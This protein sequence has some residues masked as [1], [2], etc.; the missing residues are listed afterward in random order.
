MPGDVLAA[1]F[2]DHPTA[3][4]VH[5]PP[6]DPAP[7]EHAEVPLGRLFAGQGREPARI[8]I[9]RRPVETRVQGQREL[10]I[11]VY[12]VL[13]SVGPARRMASDITAPTP[14]PRP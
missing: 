1:E 12:R 10:A 11:A 3:D 8:V 7:W 6:T 13:A 14:R 4:A 5:V 9:Y 2:Y